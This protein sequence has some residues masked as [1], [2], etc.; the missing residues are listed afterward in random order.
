M[1]EEENLGGFTKIFVLSEQ[2]MLDYRHYYEYAF[3]LHNQNKTNSLVSII[4]S[5]S[6]TQYPYFRHYFDGSA[7]H[8]LTSTSFSKAK[9]PHL[10]KDKK[11]GKI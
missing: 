5:S 10:K 4:P 11:I 2:Q 8:D 6:V 9:Q 7:K 3:E 1:Y